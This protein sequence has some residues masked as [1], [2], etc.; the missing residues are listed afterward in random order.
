MIKIIR[1][2]LKITRIIICH[3]KKLYILISIL[4][5]I[6]TYKNC[7]KALKNHCIKNVSNSIT[8]SDSNFF[9]FTF[10]PKESYLLTIP[11]SLI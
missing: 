6:I 4:N 5:I 10:F 8:K 1:F 7:Y 11:F 3:L 2:V 9:F